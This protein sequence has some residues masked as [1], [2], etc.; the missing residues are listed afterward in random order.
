MAGVLFF[1]LF[2]C[3]FHSPL[4]H[5]FAFIII[6]LLLR[7]VRVAF[8]VNNDI[9]HFNIDQIYAISAYIRFATV[10]VHMWKHEKTIKLVDPSNVGWA[11]F[12]E[13]AALAFW[14]WCSVIIYSVVRV[15]IHFLCVCTLSCSHSIN[16]TMKRASAFALCQTKSFW[17]RIC[18]V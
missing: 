17:Q 10:E 16:H 18:Y 6:F 11:R 15:Y 7:C 8:F 5:T 1:L 9:A 12:K 3:S 4:F 13:N 14:Y 2:R